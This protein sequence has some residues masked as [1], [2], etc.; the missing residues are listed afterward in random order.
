MK[1]RVLHSFCSA[2]QGATLTVT[3]NNQLQPK[4]CAINVKIILK[5]KRTFRK[6]LLLRSLTSLTFRILKPCAA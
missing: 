1:S 4:H 3:L 5:I 2:F 6:R